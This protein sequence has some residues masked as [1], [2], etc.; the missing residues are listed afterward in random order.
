[1]KAVIMTAELNNGDRVYTPEMRERLSA[2]YEFPK[3]IVNKKN[4]SEYRD[5]LKETEY[6]FTTWGMEHFTKEE[7]AEFF[8]NL[9]C[10]FYAAGSVQHFA[11]EFLQSG[12]RV[13]SAWQ[14]N[15]V[16]V[17]EYTY[18][19]IVL[20]LKGFYR[21]ERK[22]RFAFWKSVR[23]SDSCGGNYGAKVGLIGCGMIGGMVAE[24]LKANDCEVYCCDPFLPDERALSLGV[25]KASLEE[26]F[27]ECDVI[28]NHLA[29]KEELTGILSEKLFMSMKPY[30]AFINTGRGRQV[31][32]KGLVRAMKAKKTRT[33]LLDVT[34]KEPYPPFGGLA[35]CKNIIL[36][37]H[38]AGSNGREVVRMAEYMADE[39]A[40]VDGSEKT[41][42]EVT[43]EMLKTMA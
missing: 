8:P 31:D 13:F 37:P 35:R 34:I 30:A 27:S 29:N 36:T 9:K 1:M 14:A 32:E 39:A 12:V 43:T 40:R 22:S 26:I 21:A 11:R 7:I 6:I 10:V 41:L 23:Y 24:K 19:Q 18:A 4:L 20:A 17:A 42:Y 33:A 3:E 15:A 2:R 38:I 25:K 16:P 28:S 5:Y